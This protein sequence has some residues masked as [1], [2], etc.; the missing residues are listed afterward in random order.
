[1]PTQNDLHVDKLLSDVAISV[2]QS[3]DAFIASKAFPYKEVSNQSDKY[4][5]IPAGEFNRNQMRKRANAT[6]SAG[7][8]WKVSTDSYFCDVFALHVDIGDQQRANADAPFALN[9]NSSRFLAHQS[10]QAK[11]ALFA[12]TAMTTGVWSTDNSTPNW[13]SGSSTPI[14]D[15]RTA[16]RTMQLKSGFRPNKGVM[17]RD[18]FD[19]LMDHPDFLARVTNGTQSGEAAAVSKRIIAS[20]F[21]L[22]EILVMDAIVNTAAEG[23]AATNAFH[24]TEKFLLTHTAPLSLEGA[25]TAGAIFN[26]SGLAGKGSMGTRIKNIRMEHLEADRIEI[27]SAFDIKVTAPDLGYFFSGLLS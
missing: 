11:E 27:Q 12:S 23:Q 19:V 4:A 9:A 20:M 16:A 6:E 24:A 25:P 3:P 13:T 26:W 2:I 10:L 5:K 17:T 8:N 15:V 7:G 22:D 14:A 18:V 1:M 21:D